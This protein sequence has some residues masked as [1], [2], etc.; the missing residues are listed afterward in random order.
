MTLLRLSFTV[1][2]AVLSTQHAI[3]QVKAGGMQSGPSTGA[4]YAGGMY[5][6]QGDDTVYMTGI[7][8]SDQL[9]SNA[10]QNLFMG[11]SPGSDKSSCFVASMRLEFDDESKSY[12]FAGIEDFRSSVNDVN[13]E[14]CMALTLH[15]PSQIVVIGTKETGA[16]TSPP[17][18]GSVAI[19]E[20]NNLNN[21]KLSETTL[22][23]QDQSMTQLVYPMAIA[24]D[25]K[26]NDYKYLV[27]LTSKD[28]QDNSNSVGGKYPDWLKYQRYG[29]SFDMHVSKI[30]LS[31]GNGGGIDGIPTGSIS[32]SKE[33]TAEFP[34]DNPDDRVFIGG[35][36]HKTTSDNDGLVIVVGSTRGSGEGYGESEGDDEDGFVSVL[37]PST[38]ETLGLGVRVGTDEDDIVT[39]VCDDPTDPGHFYIVGATEGDMGGQQGD[40][41]SVMVPNDM[42]QPFLRQESADR[43]SSDEDNIWT[44]QWAVTKGSTSK[45]AFGSAIGCTVDGDYIYVAGTI[46]DG[47]HLVQG[48]TVIASAGG[49]DVWVAKID[50]N[51]R[52]V[53]WISQFGS[54]GDD[55]LTRYGG[56]AVD[57][58]GNPIIYGN[59]NGEI[60]RTRSASED[61]DIVDMFVMSL[62]K[63]TGNTLDNSDDVFV[64]GFTSFIV[65]DDSEVFDNPT[66][67]STDSNEDGSFDD[68]DLNPTSSPTFYPTLTLAPT[69]VANTANRDSEDTNSSNKH[70]FNPIG[71]QIQGPAHGGGIMY[72]AHANTVLLTG[73]TYLD[74]SMNVNPTSLCFTGV[75]DLNAGDLIKR[76]PR[77]SQNLNEV[78]SSITFDTNRNT[79]YS[80]GMSEADDDGYFEGKSVENKFGASG[81]PSWSQG[82]PNQKSGG[83][84]MQMDEN[85]QLLGGNRI[86]GHPTVYPISVVS[87][88]TD[89]DYLFVASMVTV[90][91]SVNDMFDDGDPYPNFLRRDSK[92]FGAGFFLSVDQY[93]VTDVPTESSDKIPRTLDK[94]WF[95][96]FRT[97]G[98]EDVL[99]GGM[100][101][102]GNGN[103]LVI[104]GSTRGEGGPYDKNDGNNDMDGFILKINPEDGNLVGD[105]KSSTRLDSVNNKDDY[106][107]NVC[108]D[109]FD[110]DAIYVVG[111]S[112]GHI[113]D[114]SEEDQPPAGSSHAYIAKVDLESMKAEW[115][116][117]FTMSIP[118]D[119]EM[120]GEALACTVTHDENGENIVYVGGTVDNG[121]LMDS[122]TGSTVAH[123]GDD[124]F[125][126]AMNGSNGQMLWIQQM[127]TRMDDSLVSGQGLD[128][129]SFGNVIVYAE[130]FGDFYDKHTNDPDAPD[131]VIYTMNKQDGTYLTPRTDGEGVGSDEVS[132]D[133]LYIPPEATNGIQALQTDDDTIPSYAGGM[134]Y[135]KFTNAVYVT[136]ASYTLDGEKV[137]KTSQCLFG[138]ATLPQLQWKQMN[139][140][141]TSKAP[142][143]CSSISLANYNGESEPIIVGSSEKSGLL[144]NLRNA[145]RS[146][147]YG[148]V[149]DLQNNGG[150]FDLV[151]GTV[152]DEEKVQFPVKVLS[153]DEKIFLVSMA[154]KSDEVEPDSEKSDGKK[155]PNLTTGGIQKYGAQYEILVERHTLNRESDLPPGSM[156][157]TMSLNWRKPL[158]TADKRS[159][160]VSGMAMIDDGDSLIVV[161]STQ[162]VEKDSDF[163]GIMAKISTDDGSFALEGDESRSV[164][165][166]AS[167]SGANDWLLNVCPD[168]N[169]KRFFYVV[170]ATG[171][172]MDSSISK[173][174][175][176][177][178]VHAVVSKIQTNTLNIIWSTQYEV[179]HAS[180]STGKEAAA[181]ALGCAMVPDQNLLYV[182]GDV[183]NGAVL[184]GATESAGADDIFVAMLDTTTG[185]KIWTKQV[186]SDGDD[187]IARGGGIIVDANGNAVVFGDTTG[188]FHR[189]RGDVSSQTSDLF[190]M[191]FKQDDASHEKP[192]NKQTVREKKKAAKQ[193]SAPS[194]WFGATYTKDP[195]LVGMLAGAILSA[196]VLLVS[197][198]VLYRRTRA[199]HELA[200]ENHIFTYLQ[201]FSVHDIDLRKSPPGGWHGT[202]LNKLAH[203]VNT[204]TSLP[205]QY[206]DEH[207]DEDTQVLFESAKMVHANVNNSLFM[208]TTSAP[209][210]GGYSDYVDVDENPLQTRNNNVI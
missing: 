197:C 7:H 183:E 181:V 117:H 58:T 198:A 83:V 208:D 178:T 157:S 167:V 12:A 200:K 113:R 87:H 171:G 98:G 4:M 106:I 96:D 99:V 150:S 68:S 22:V 73:A 13:Q 69:R 165:Y 170:G 10:M 173:S 135:D 59:T 105:S 103:V 75:V 148:M 20:R 149:L 127:G 92:E 128:V 196:L 44:M 16:S 204:A 95:S 28:A 48:Q 39:G 82:E 77:G 94:T 30:K 153:D 102:A 45:P 141:G 9:Q 18:E 111:K 207:L 81:A 29:S 169:D 86:V 137:S 43:D 122:N 205:E 147:Q 203:G 158:E 31:Q 161:G 162:D 35:I 104:V 49:A 34:L 185:D 65:D 110:H 76:T 179:T 17:I 176:D 108:N 152:V 61:S 131:L 154:S 138:I 78:C 6:D 74:A 118:G 159:I 209:S 8:Y 41:N 88:P 199:R 36:I 56:I 3:I 133:A 146:S 64:G 47:A 145:R 85:L 37:D 23:D 130:T 175:N 89:K 62:D 46:D 164:A 194:E 182:A 2:A 91:T 52:R 90:D 27:V 143:A 24:S 38:G 54:D 187:R 124:I 155:Y 97:D 125:V 57:K 93:K 25:S 116:Y 21:K 177:A 136:G 129:D 70:I 172:E 112:E 115:L 107:S 192:L 186:G 60:Y 67:D 32:A 132:E 26:S 79:V 51:S 72:D 11:S 142:D 191:T 5:I 42:L 121:A 109:R 151:G 71:L 174:E 160:F 40:L 119:G 114:L 14:A 50:K 210:L 188:S 156:E 202:Y 15:R 1:L 166:F 195:K 120:N 100:T 123:G 180:G 144:D 189:M 53:K 63:D 66:V 80:V 84:I 19:F 101:I 139:T 33:W 163:D 140:M 193:D 126:A 206:K 190:L 55:R 134:H 184:E 201:Q 168:T